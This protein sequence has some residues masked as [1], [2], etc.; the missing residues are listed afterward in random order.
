M[1]KLCPRTFFQSFFRDL[2]FGE[3]RR[4]LLPANRVSISLKTNVPD[5]GID[6][7][8]EDALLAQNGDVIVDKDVFYQ[9]KSGRNFEPWK[10]S[11]VKEEILGKEDVSRENMAEY[12]RECFDKRGTYVLVCSKVQLTPQ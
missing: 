12:V 3:A 7:P 5:G 1:W 6:A 10:A 9:L 11:V 2:L 8:V 4:L